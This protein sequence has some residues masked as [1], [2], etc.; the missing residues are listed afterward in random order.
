MQTRIGSEIYKP[1][2]EARS[3]SAGRVELARMLAGKSK[4][5]AELATGARPVDADGRCTDVNP[6][7]QL[8][9]NLSGPPWGAALRRTIAAGSGIKPGANFEDR[10]PPST[11]LECFGVTNSFV[12][13]PILIWNIPFDPLPHPFVAPLSRGYVVFRAHRTTGAIST[14]LEVRAWNVSMSETIE[15]ASRDIVTLGALAGNEATSTTD[16]FVR[17]RSGLN[18]VK[19]LFFCRTSGHEVMVDSWALEQRAK[20]SH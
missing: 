9:V 15:N 4:V 18:V 8:G 20:I 3:E 17:L 1:D 7:G 13:G 12:I 11:A 16:L 5:L 10:T 2:S 6:Q 19:L 14:D